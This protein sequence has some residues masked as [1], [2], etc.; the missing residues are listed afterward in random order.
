MKSKIS[1][2]IDMDVGDE[3]REKVNTTFEE[4]LKEKGISTQEKI[5]L[6]ETQGFFNDFIDD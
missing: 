6:H 3:W 1:K 4:L 2:I 5:A